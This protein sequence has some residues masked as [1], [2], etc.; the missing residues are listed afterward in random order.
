MGSKLASFDNNF[1][2]AR[3]VN[4]YISLTMDVAGT[5]LEISADTS[6]PEPLSCPHCFL[7]YGEFSHFYTDDFKGLVSY[8]QTHGLLLSEKVCPECKS[9]CRIDLQKKGFCWNKSV[10]RGHKPHSLD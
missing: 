10:P 3:L 2:Q 9:V 4:H 6:T 1:F 7:S 5:S 8:V